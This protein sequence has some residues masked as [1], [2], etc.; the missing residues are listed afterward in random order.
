MKSTFKSW[1]LK[2]IDYSPPRGWASCNQSMISIEQRPISLSKK[3]FCQK[4]VFGL[5]L[6]H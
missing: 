1:S 4:T 6:H 2:E 5:E 3:E